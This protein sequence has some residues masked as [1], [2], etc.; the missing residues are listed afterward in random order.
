MRARR[1][2]EMYKKYCSILGAHLSYA[3]FSFMW[4]YGNLIAY[5]DS[6]FQFACSKKCLDADS[7]WIL[8]MFVAG[9]FPGVFLVKPLVNRIGLK[10]TGMVTMVISNAATLGSAWSL[11]LSVA[12]T[13]VIYAIFVGPCVGIC[14]SVA[15]QVV[16]GWTPRWTGVFMAT[17]TGF[18]TVLSMFQNQ[19]ITAYINPR[20]LKTDAMVGV[21]AYFSQPEILNRVPNT[22]I[23]MSFMTFVLQF[24]GYALITNPPNSSQ[25]KIKANAVPSTR[26]NAGS[27]ELVN[28]QP[29][30]GCVNGSH[31]QDIKNFRSNKKSCTTKSL[32]IGQ[33]Y[34]CEM[35]PLESSEHRKGDIDTPIS[36]KP[37]EV[38]LSSAYYAILLACMALEFSLQMKANFYKQFGQLYI[39]NDRYLTLI[40]TLVPV[41]S[42]LSR[43]VFGALHDKGYLSL[44]DVAVI[45]LSVNSVLCAFWYIVPQ[46]SAIMYMFLVLGLAV[47]QSLFYVLIFCAALRLFGPDHLSTNYALTVLCILLA[48]IMTPIVV[49]L[50]LQSLGWFWLLTYCSI[51]S[52]MTLVFVVSANFDTQRQK[53]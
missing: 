37:S 5:M 35:T 52:L 46:V 45:G 47:A 51:F 14:T 50:F 30:H 19:I 13:A 10:W 4:Y 40:G 9:Q 32:D 48:S 25:G 28:S 11:Q 23:I 27:D 24:A 7:Q 53:Q 34:Q 38:F 6:Y 1:H 36:W 21:S 33:T 43:V 22:V 18:A 44:K 20:N 39:H 15:L 12:W 26:V 29:L 2:G 3:P 41:T 42:T 8:A 31:K 16:C 17:V 49:R